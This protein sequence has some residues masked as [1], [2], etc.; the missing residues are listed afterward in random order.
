MLTV[1]SMF[2][3][4]AKFDTLKTAAIEFSVKLEPLS[5]YFGYYHL[6]AKSVKE[7]ITATV[8]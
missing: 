5:S 6:I 2:D 1:D 7:Y 4:T 3:L 8:S